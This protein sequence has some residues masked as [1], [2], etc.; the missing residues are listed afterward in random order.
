MLTSLVV[1]SY[2]PNFR[3]KVGGRAR[4]STPRPLHPRGFNLYP[5]AYTAMESTVNEARGRVQSVRHKNGL[6]AGI[7]RHIDRHLYPSAPYEAG[8]GERYAVPACA[9]AAGTRRHRGDGLP[10]FGECCGRGSS[11]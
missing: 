1:S 8:I 10:A 9:P 7:D 2:R 5:A 3:F 6:G 4:F 11:P